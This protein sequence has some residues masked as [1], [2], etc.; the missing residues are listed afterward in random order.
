MLLKVGFIDW[1]VVISAWDK[2]MDFTIEI[3]SEEE[4]GSGGADPQ[5]PR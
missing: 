2:R 3:V 4:P 1:L 5:T